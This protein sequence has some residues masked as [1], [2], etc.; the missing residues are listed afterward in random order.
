MEPQR[1]KE[2]AK[3]NRTE[4]N[5]DNEEGTS[6]EPARYSSLFA[7]FPSVQFPVLPVFSL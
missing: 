7:S 5:E 6:V 2:Q 1:Q 3:K 4:G